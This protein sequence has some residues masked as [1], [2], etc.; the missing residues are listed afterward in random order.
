M[1]LWWFGSSSLSEI[2]DPEPNMNTKVRFKGVFIE[3]NQGQ[4]NQLL[5]C[6]GVQIPQA[7]VKQNQTY[8]YTKLVEPGDQAGNPWKEWHEAHLDLA[9][10]DSNTGA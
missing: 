4:A 10:K 5:T 7:K 6:T 8:G 2:S 3:R 1:L 9:L